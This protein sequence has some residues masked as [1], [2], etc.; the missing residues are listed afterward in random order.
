MA[1]KIDENF[2]TAKEIATKITN[3]YGIVTASGRI[4]VSF[5]RS[6]LDANMKASGLT[7]LMT[8]TG[9]V[10]VYQNY[11]EVFTFL[12]KV[13]EELKAAKAMV[14][15]LSTTDGIESHRLLYKPAVTFIRKKP[16]GI[17]YDTMP[18]YTYDIRSSHTEA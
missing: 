9:K 18:R 15:D 2:P 8:S 16:V 14:F 17:P 6:F 5:V 11:K 4:P 1:V 12:D 3:K 7:R 13:F 10:F